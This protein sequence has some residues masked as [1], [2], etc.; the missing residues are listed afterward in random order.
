MPVYG[1]V[2]TFLGS[3]PHVFVHRQDNAVFCREP[4]VP[5]SGYAPG[6]HAPEQAASGMGGASGSGDA[7]G[8]S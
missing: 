3:K 7:A 2:H 4:A 1:P 5:A 8:P 6:E